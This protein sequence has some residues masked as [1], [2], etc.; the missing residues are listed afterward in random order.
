MKRLVLA[1][2]VLAMAGCAPV[3]GA[4]PPQNASVAGTRWQV[5]EIKG[6]ATPASD[7]Y[8]IS[9]ERGQLGARFGCNHMGG[10][11][12]QVGGTIHVGQV[13]STL[14]GCPEPAGTFEAEAGAILSQPMSATWI[15]RD[16][17]ELSNRAGGMKLVR[18]P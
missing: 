6:R 1:G 7:L 5:V 11:Y 2:A 4:I 10:S 16:R 18:L 8:R 15:S 12:Q 3:A 13:A 17:L 9:F 14:M